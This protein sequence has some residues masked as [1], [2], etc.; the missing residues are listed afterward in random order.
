MKQVEHPPREDHVLKPYEAKLLKYIR[1]HWALDF[2]TREVRLLIE[3]Q[4]GVPVLIRV[5]GNTVKEEKLR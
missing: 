2:G 1:S 3:Y 4:D 5:T